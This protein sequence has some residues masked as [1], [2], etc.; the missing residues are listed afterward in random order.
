MLGPLEIKQA[1]LAFTKYAL[2]NAYKVLEHH[3]E[4]PQIIGPQLMLKSLRYTLVH[5]GRAR[6]LQ[7]VLELLEIGESIPAHLRHSVDDM[8]C[9][10]D[11]PSAYVPLSELSIEP[12]ITCT[13][14]MCQL[15]LECHV[16]HVESR[17]GQ[18]IKD[19]CDKI[20]REQGI[21]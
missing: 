8:T 11:V 17:L 14:L 10:L 16:G 7:S 6:D 12:N 2:E 19:V 15:V 3:P 4:A 21:Y 9:D 5:D 13:C 20:E 18:I 1:C